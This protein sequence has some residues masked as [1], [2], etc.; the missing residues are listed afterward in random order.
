[1]KMIVNLDANEVKNSLSSLL[2][3]DNLDRRAP[4][5]LFCTFS[6]QYFSCSEAVDEDDVVLP[7]LNAGQMQAMMKTSIEKLK[8]AFV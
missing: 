6:C 2:S 4:G 1:M 7:K 8:L 5:T 3:G